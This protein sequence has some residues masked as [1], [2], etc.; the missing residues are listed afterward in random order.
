YTDFYLRTV[1]SQARETGDK[2]LG[3]KG[4]R[5]S[6]SERAR[7]LA[8]LQLSRRI[9]KPHERLADLRKQDR[10]GRG[11]GERAARAT[12]QDGAQ[13]GLERTDLMADR[14]RGDAKLVRGFG[15]AEVTR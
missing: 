13:M 2:P 14:P 12:E 1:L 6:D 5:H 3:G 4:G 9:V 8:T 11:K 15:E 10:S 7:Q